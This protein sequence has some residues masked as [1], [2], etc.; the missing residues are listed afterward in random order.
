MNLS[1]GGRKD[2]AKEGTAKSALSHVEITLTL[3]LET[4]PQL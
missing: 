4:K 3:T 1:E 2:K